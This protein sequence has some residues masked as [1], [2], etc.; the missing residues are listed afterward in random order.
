[1]AKSKLDKKKPVLQRVEL[2]LPPSVLD[3]VQNLADLEGR[4]RK[5]YLE[6]LVIDHVKKKIN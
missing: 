1:M 6:R 2:F 4:S 3:E 5:N